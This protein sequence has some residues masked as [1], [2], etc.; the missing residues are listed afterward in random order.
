MGVA[1]NDDDEDESDAEELWGSSCKWLSSSKFRWTDSH[2]TSDEQLI[3]ETSQ[4]RF[5]GLT[6]GSKPSDGPDESRKSIIYSKIVSWIVPLYFSSYSLLIIH[7]VFK[8]KQHYMYDCDSVW[9]YVL[10]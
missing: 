9:I 10:D 2:G 1:D 6:P 8:N 4:R 7:Q 3:G 5:D